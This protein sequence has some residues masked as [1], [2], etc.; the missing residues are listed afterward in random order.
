V[1]DDVEDLYH[2]ISVTL[3]KEQLPEDKWI[4]AMEF[5][6]GSE[7]VHHVIAYG[8]AEGE[9]DRLNR[10][11]LGGLAPGTDDSN[12]PEGYGKI[13]PAESTVVFQMHYHKEPGP[14]TGRW[15]DTKLAL[16][17]H[18][19][20]VQH[21]IMTTPVAHGDFEIPPLVDNWRVGGARI[22]HED[23]DLI[24][25][26]PH[27]HLRGK[28][29]K[30]TAYYPDGSSEVLLE[31]PKYDFNWQTSYSFKDIKKLPKGTRVEWEIR[32]DNSPERAERVG[33]NAE[34]AVRFGRPTTDEMD[35]GWMY[36]SP[37]KPIGE[38]GG[39]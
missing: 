5:Q 31:V 10:V 6:P 30:Y 15:D 13:L 17:F 3:T 26:M 19:K 20:P 1:A 32:Y 23:I 25:L 18:D 8:V 36:Y 12:F 29:A 22:F 16:K 35:L 39:D 11:H 24:G 7:V 33:F 34:R 14:G 9:G 28:Y 37:S 21:Q 27:T 2:D 38:V 4:K